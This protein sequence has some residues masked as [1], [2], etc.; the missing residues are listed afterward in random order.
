MSKATLISLMLSLTVL[1]VAPVRA[2]F[3]G[4]SDF[5]VQYTVDNSMSPPQ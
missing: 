3:F 2:Q 4:M 5:D 1:L